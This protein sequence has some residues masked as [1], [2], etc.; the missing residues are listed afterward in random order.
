MGKSFSPDL[1]PQMTFTKMSLFIVIRYII[2]YRDIFVVNVHDV[3]GGF[4]N[5]SHS[6]KQPCMPLDSILVLDMTKLLLSMC[7][8]DHQ[9][10]LVSA[11]LFFVK[12]V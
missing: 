4:H 5:W 12:A 6:S 1:H 11:F 3:E 2:R 8:V 9:A 10:P 7:L